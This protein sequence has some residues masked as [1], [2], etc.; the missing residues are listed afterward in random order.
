VA[1]SI[2]LTY[3]IST[4]SRVSSNVTV[5]VFLEV[6]CDLSTKILMAVAMFSHSS[7]YLAN[8]QNKENKEEN[9]HPGYG[10]LVPRVAVGLFGHK[11]SYHLPS[12]ATLSYDM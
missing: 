11:V 3:H 4:A 12:V 8:I 9:L 5:D 10:N 2:T 1:Y 7:T 6:V